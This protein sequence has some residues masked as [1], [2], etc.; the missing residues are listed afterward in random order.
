VYATGTRR[1]TGTAAAF[2]RPASVS[3]PAAQEVVDKFDP[4]ALA[5]VRPAIVPH[6]TPRCP[7][8]SDHPPLPLHYWLSSRD[9]RTLAHPCCTPC[10][11]THRN[12][13]RAISSLYRATPPVTSEHFP[14][15]VARLIAN[16]FILVTSCVR[17]QLRLLPSPG[18]TRL[19]RYYEPPRDPKR[20]GLSL[21]R[22]RLI[23][24]AITAGASRVA[25]GPR[26][27]HAIANTLAELMRLIARDSTSDFPRVSAGRLLR[28]T[29]RGLLSVYSHYG[30]H[31][32]KSPSRPSTPEASAASSPLPLLR[33]L[34]GGA[35]QFPGGTCT[36]C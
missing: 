10:R 19:L 34:P 7:R 4:S 28:C 12:G 35:I 2:S 17:F 26:C 25:P 20:P 22:F 23:P 21:V 31:A 24:T 27:I 29:F 6:H 16:P 33:L 8:T 15:W 1:N 18:V 13:N 30:L 36:R 5:S 9:K 11:T 14:G 3:R 32:P